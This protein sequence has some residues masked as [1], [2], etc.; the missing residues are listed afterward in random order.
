MRIISSIIAV[1]LI[2]LGLSFALLNANPV[3]LNYY[4]G[5]IRISLSLLLVLAVGLGILIGFSISIGSI[6]K[7]KRKNHLYKNRVKQLEQEIINH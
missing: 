1:I 3:V 2:I 5:N 4:V 7:L 6:L